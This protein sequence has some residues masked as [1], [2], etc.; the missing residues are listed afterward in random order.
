MDTTSRRY[1]WSGF[2]N[3]GEYLSSLPHTLGLFA[4]RAGYVRDAGAQLADKE[5]AGQQMAKVLNWFHGFHRP[6][7]V[8][9]FV[10]AGL[11]ALLSALCYSEFATQYPLAGGAYNYIA[12]TMGELVAWLTVTT[13]V[14][15]YIL[16]NAAVARA[17]SAYFATLIGKDAGFFIIPYKDYS[18]DFLAAG[19]MIGCCLMLMFTTA[20][21]SWFNIVVTG[22]QL[23]VILIILIV[24]FIKANPANM[25]PFLPF[26]VR[27]IFNGASFVFFSFIGFDCVS[28]LAEEVKNP[29]VDMPVGIVGCI[30]FVGIIYT[31]M[32]LCLVMMVPYD[33][34]D[35][36]AS[37]STAFRQVGLPW[38]SYLVALGATLGIVTGVLVGVMGV[39]RIVC[40]MGRSHLIFPIFGK[41]HDR[42]GT[43]MWATLFVTIAAVP[44]CILTDLPALIDMV[45][46]G[47]LMVFAVVAL[48]LI[49]KRIV[50]TGVPVSQNALP[51]SLIGLLVASCI[52]FACVFALLTD[53][54]KSIGMGITGG[55]ALL[56]CIV[57]R[58][59]CKQYDKPSYR[60]PGH[61]FLPATSLLLNCFLMA[62][63]SGRAYMQLAIFFG[64]VLVFYLLYSV[65]ASERFEKTGRQAAVEGQKAIDL[66]CNA[67]PSRRVS[68]V[69][70]HSPARQL[71][72]LT[73][74]SSVI[75]GMK[76]GRASG[77]VTML[78]PPT[79]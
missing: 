70:P 2:T 77:G 68:S 52:A 73:G 66:E 72:M 34:L 41:I 42:F 18:V 13:L 56:L 3:T 17:F 44:L 8:V 48:A 49:W 9:S 24:G 63:L 11:S 39:A 36:S 15:Q 71:S 76:L 60:V 5:A 54:P 28:T 16:A 35:V 65:H 58:F 40:S 67:A 31:L 1:G 69:Q 25:S 45:S 27:G 74:E 23:I 50:R 19:L 51:L 57:I 7:I 47:T 78:P 21:G 12:L 43:P 61:P 64:V 6:A 26:G 38:A 37:F 53:L 30:T 4:K 62:S 46:A 55:V 79:M 14:M 10:I 20:G 32:S 33:Q 59:S 22:A 29:A 75:E